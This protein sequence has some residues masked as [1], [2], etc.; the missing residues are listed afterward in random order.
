MPPT[1]RL[2]AEAKAP[3]AAKQLGT[4]GGGNHFLELLYDEGGCVWIM[5]HSGS[6]GIGAPRSPLRLSGDRGDCAVLSGCL[7]AAVQRQPLQEPE[8]VWGVVSTAW[9]TLRSGRR[10]LPVHICLSNSNMGSGCARSLTAQH[11]GTVAHKRS[12]LRMHATPCRAHL[13]HLQERVCEWTRR[14][15]DCTIP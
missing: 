5:L 15:H 1:P 13:A 11:C 7:V 6:R 12:N 10:Q 4:L 2:A 14:Q 8:L 3:K 9:I